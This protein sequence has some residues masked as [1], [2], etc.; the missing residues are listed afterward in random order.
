M[1]TSRSTF[2]IDKNGLI[3]EVIEKADPKNHTAQILKEE[4]PKKKASPPKNKAA[5]P[6][7]K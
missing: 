6:K 4:K 2:V 3:E 5:S 1:G 7:K